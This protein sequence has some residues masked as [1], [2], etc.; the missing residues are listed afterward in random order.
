MIPTVFTFTA[1]TPLGVNVYQLPVALYEFR[2]RSRRSR[3]SFIGGGTDSEYLGF[4]WLLKMKWEVMDIAEWT[5]IQHIAE[6]IRA[7]YDVKLSYTGA[8]WSSFWGYDPFEFPFR[9]DL[10]DEETFDFKQEYAVLTDVEITF[11]C[12]DIVTPSWG[13]VYQP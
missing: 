5:K 10:E 7:G 4:D 11:I 6:S 2:R 1:T 13:S 8:T 9:I 12:K 3:F